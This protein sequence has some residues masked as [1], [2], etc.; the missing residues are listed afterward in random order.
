TP[1]AGAPQCVVADRRADLCDV[2]LSDCPGGVSIYHSLLAEPEGRRHAAR[3]PEYRPGPP[4]I[5]RHGRAGRLMPD[6]SVRAPALTHGARW[7]Q[8]MLCGTRPS[9]VDTGHVR[10]CFEPGAVGA[11]AVVATTAVRAS[12]LVCWQRHPYRAQSPSLEHRPDRRPQRRFV[13]AVGRQ[14]G[15][16]M[17]PWQNL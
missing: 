15:L 4:G 10:A 5:S 12:G 7:L 17:V 6:R 9:G 3:K 13:A 1:P 11:A 16:G 2:R 14:A 8:A